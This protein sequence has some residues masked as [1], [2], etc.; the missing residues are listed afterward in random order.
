MGGYGG[1][2]NDQGIVFRPHYITYTKE[3]GTGVGLNLNG[4]FRAWIV[5]DIGGRVLTVRRSVVVVV[6]ANRWNGG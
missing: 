1:K 5:V 2:V 4:L 3:L 6:A